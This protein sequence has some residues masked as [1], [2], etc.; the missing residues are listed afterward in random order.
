MGMTG[1]WLTFLSVWCVLCRLKSENLVLSL[2]RRELREE[3]RKV[4]EGKSANEVLIFELKEEV[5]R[6]GEA[7]EKN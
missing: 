6:L 1:R 7:V 3:M 5:K 2:E 4:S